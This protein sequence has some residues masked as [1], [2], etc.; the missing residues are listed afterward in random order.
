MKKKTNY[1]LKFFEHKPV[2]E[3]KR[4]KKT[5]F[6]LGPKKILKLKI[7]LKTD[8]SHHSVEMYLW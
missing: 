1:F 5:Y 4:K 3:K 7:K 8:N 2:F 6:S